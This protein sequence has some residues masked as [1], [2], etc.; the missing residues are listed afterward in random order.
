MKARRGCSGLL[1]TGARRGAEFACDGSYCRARRCEISA[2]QT[3]LAA[4]ISRVSMPEM[5][6]RILSRFAR[7]LQPPCRD[8]RDYRAGPCLRHDHRARGDEDAA[9]GGSIRAR[10]T[11]D[12]TNCKIILTEVTALETIRDGI[13]YPTTVKK[14]G[15]IVAFTVGLSRLS[16]NSATAKADI[17]FLDQTYG[18]TT[19][20]AV[21]VLAP[22]GAKKLRQ[23]KV[24]A[25]S[26]IFHVQPYLGEVVQLP[27]QTS[28]PVQRGDVVALTTPTW[29][30]VRCRS[31]FPA[32]KQSPAPTEPL[33]Q[34]HPSRGHLA[35]PADGQAGRATVTKCDYFRA[36]RVEY[37]ATEITTPGRALISG[38]GSRADR[39]VSGYQ[40]RDAEPAVG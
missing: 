38:I 6:K 16:T 9:F 18:G 35:G 19:Q 29:A 15:S 21:T 23:W 25:S 26:T 24:V 3:Q 10:R 2:E 36:R 4:G 27:L 5:T 34:L 22:A 1:L 33:G 31:N 28:L 13:A 30:P 8:R 37:T 40:A 7:S 12:A 11:G 14:A 17:H 32:A 20:L 39:Q